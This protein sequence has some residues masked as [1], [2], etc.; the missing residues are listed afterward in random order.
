MSRAPVNVLLCVFWCT[1]AKMLGVSLG[2]ELPVLLRYA[3]AE[4]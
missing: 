1:C 3:Y 2:A 4:P